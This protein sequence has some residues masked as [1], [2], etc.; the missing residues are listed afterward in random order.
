MKILKKMDCIECHEENCVTLKTVT[1]K[2]AVTH[3]VSKCALCRKV[4]DI[5]DY[6]PVYQSLVNR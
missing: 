6:T 3:S 4:Q 1:T 5:R 2:T